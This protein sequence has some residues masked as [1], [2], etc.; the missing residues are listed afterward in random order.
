MQKTGRE[1]EREREKGERDKE[2][3]KS[4]MTQKK[5]CVSC[6]FTLSNTPRTNVAAALNPLRSNPPSGGM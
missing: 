3:E 5:H 6:R 4:F 1:R 2:R